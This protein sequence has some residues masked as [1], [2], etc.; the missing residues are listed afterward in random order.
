[1]Q[2]NHVVGPR[3]QNLSAVLPMLSGIT[4]LMAI[5]T[6]EAQFPASYTTSHNTIS[7]LGSTW[8]PGNIAREPSATIFNTT[9][10]VA[11]LMIAAGA[12]AFW[13]AYRSGQSRSHCCYSAL[14]CSG[15]ASSRDRDWRARQRR[16]G[17]PARLEC[18]PLLRDLSGKEAVVAQF[19]SSAN[20]KLR[21][22]CCA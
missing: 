6:G 3:A 14:A 11:G 18:S 22:G 4:I 9:M 19:E 13:R 5:I 8:Q 17:T 1:M 20:S 12:A 21:C 15:W 2:S 10:L 7:D 16:R